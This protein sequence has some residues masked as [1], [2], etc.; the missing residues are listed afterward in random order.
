MCILLNANCQKQLFNAL[1]IYQLNTPS[2]HLQY[3]N[4]YPAWFVHFS[5]IMLCEVSLMRNSPT[6]Q[7]ACFTKDI[8]KNNTT[9]T[10]QRHVNTN[11]LWKACPF[12]DTL[13]QNSYICK[14]RCEARILLAGHQPFAQVHWLI[15]QTLFQNSTG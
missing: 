2:T 12:Y 3:S 7:A 11:A 9:T 4:A 8:T 1:N 5:E 6:H 10:T 13:S 15:H 14:L